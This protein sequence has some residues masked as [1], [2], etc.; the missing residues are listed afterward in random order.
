MRDAAQLLPDMHSGDTR[1]Q[2]EN[3]QEPNNDG[4]HYDGI[5]YGLDGRRHGDIAVDQ[6]EDHTD[7]DQEEQNLNHG[8]CIAPFRL[9]NYSLKRR[10][11]NPETEK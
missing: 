5:Q 8:H 2:A 4:D 7:D 3:I 9:E 1:K 11:E 6:R 10:S